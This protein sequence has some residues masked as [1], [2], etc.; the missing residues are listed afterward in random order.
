[1]TASRL[2]AL[3]LFGVTGDLARKKAD[4]IIGGGGG[5]HDPGR[6]GASGS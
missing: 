3:V 5:W 2:D 1:M 4:A 6:N